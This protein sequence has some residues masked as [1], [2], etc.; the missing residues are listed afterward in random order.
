MRTGSIVLAA[1]EAK[2]FGKNKLLQHFNG[3]PIIN[4]VIDAVSFLDRVIIVGR[5]AEELL[6]YL[7][8]EIVIYNPRW[9]LGLSESIKIGVRF[10]QDY[11]AVLIVLGD[12][13]LL[14]QDTIKKII[15]SYNT[16]CSAV[17]P[18]YQGTRG[19][20]V[21]ISRAL[22]ADLM[23]LEGDIGAREILKNRKDACL[24][25]AGKEVIVD[26]DTEFD[27]TSLQQT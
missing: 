7:K 10:F 16:E 9:K 8:N 12:M 6:P 24:V 2:R 1:G 23:K 22:F 26:V 21:L 13:P 17:V 14:T 5:Y 20:P 4:S 15:S 3:K 19:N 27:L 11:D 18:E 25:E